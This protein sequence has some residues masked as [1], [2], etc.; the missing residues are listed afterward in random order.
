[1]HERV[2]SISHRRARP[3][4]F[5]MAALAVFVPAAAACGGGGGGGS[6]ATKSAVGGK[7]DV[8]AFDVHYDVGTIDASLGPLTVTLHERGAQ[9]HTF[10]V[11]NGPPFELKVS[12]GSP[13]ATGTV[14]LA[15]GTYKFECTVPGHAA[16][17]HGQIV[18]G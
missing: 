4:L 9:N 14:T 6:G 3:A 8:E 7:I 1:M 11:L 10:K 13:T 5:A 18:V 16:T 2:T 17:M 15:K 12:P